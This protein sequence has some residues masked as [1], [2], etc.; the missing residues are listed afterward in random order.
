MIVEVGACHRD[1]TMEEYIA[2]EQA[3]SGLER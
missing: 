1:C 3:A 2:F